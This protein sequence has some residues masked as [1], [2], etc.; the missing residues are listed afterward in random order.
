MK[1]TRLKNG[2]VFQDLGVK[3]QL[4]TTCCHVTQFIKKNYI[5]SGLF[6]FI[7]YALMGINLMV[8][9]NGVNNLL[10]NV[11]LFLP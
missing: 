8:C 10:R 4:T 7:I 2:V 6:T 5:I 9:G 3:G 11:Y 1:R